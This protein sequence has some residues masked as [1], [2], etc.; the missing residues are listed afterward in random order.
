MAN[1]FHRK[2][3]AEMERPQVGH[4][5]MIIILCWNRSRNGEPM[6]YT[7]DNLDQQLR[8]SGLQTSQGS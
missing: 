4:R 2:Y 6:P 7:L 8:K 3:D 1:S 5:D